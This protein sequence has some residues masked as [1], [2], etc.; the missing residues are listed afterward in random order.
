MRKK[1]FTLKEFNGETHNTDIIDPYYTSDDTYRKV[2]RII[3][4]H[5]EKAI[6][7]IKRMNDSYE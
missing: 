4:D 6:K 1:T 5:V 3:E 7:K 2:L